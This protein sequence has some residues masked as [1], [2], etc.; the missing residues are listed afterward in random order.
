MATDPK[1]YYYDAGG[2]ETISIIKAKLSSEQFQG[3][4]LGNA[5]KYI[6]RANWKGDFSRD[7][8]K[9]RQYLKWAQESCDSDSPNSA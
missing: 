4:L 6:L 8:E 9:A 5:I 7:I 1:S 3:Y 2:I